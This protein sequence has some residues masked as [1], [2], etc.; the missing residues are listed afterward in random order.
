[1]TLD[2]NQVLVRRLHSAFTIRTG[3]SFYSESENR[4]EEKILVLNNQSVQ[5]IRGIWKTFDLALG[6]PEIDKQHLW[7]IAILVDLEE[8]LEGGNGAKLQESFS[9]ALTKTLDY[10]LEHFALEEKLLESINFDKLGQH[11]LQHSRFI[12]ALRRR[13][14]ENVTEDFRQAG[15]DLLKNLKKWLFRHILGEDKA[16]A[17]AAKDMMSLETQE[18]MQNRLE[19]SP[20]RDEIEVLYSLVVHS[21]E[22]EISAEFKNVG[23]DN[24]KAISELWYRYRLRTGIA[25]VDMQHL[26]LLQLLVKTDKLYKQKLRQE[27]NNNSLSRQLKNAIT[28]TIEYIREHFNTEE[29]IMHHFHFIGEK[30]H[31]KQHESFNMLIN[32][33]AERSE[34]E[35]MEA[36]SLLL[37]DLKEWLISHIAI[38]DKKLFYFFRSRLGD[39]NDFV[40][41]MNQEGKIHIWKDAVTIYKL[42]VDYEDISMNQ[43]PRPHSHSHGTGVR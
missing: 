16:Y 23:E 43:H 41:Q 14:R 32:D 26:W 37:Q 30:N 11:R 15:L 6:I 19:H 8:K 12:M 38:E 9:S 22:Q 28:E 3:P 7:L 27:I 21:E 18:W 2:I 36:I 42:L 25:I 34:K 10:T 39:V 5:K 4:L 1:M 13:A 33:L 40:R 24:L 17:E 20:Y 29:A 35:E 31:I